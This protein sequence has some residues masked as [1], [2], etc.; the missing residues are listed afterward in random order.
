M[1]GQW[2]AYRKNHGPISTCLYCG[3]EYYS[4]LQVRLKLIQSGITQTTPPYLARD[5][6]EALDIAFARLA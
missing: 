4:G 3:D 6:Q 2:I 5:E 1:K